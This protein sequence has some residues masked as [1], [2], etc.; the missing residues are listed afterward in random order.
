MRAL[1]PKTLAFI[2]KAAVYI[3]L[4]GCAGLS[5]AGSATDKSAYHEFGV[6][7]KAVLCVPSSDMDPVLISYN[8]ES[9]DLAVGS[10]H[11]PGFGFLFDAH[12]VQR[13]LRIGMFRVRPEL[14]GLPHANTLGG[15]VGFLSLPD[16]RRLGPA[17]RARDLEDEWS[18]SGRCPNTVVT[19]F[20]Q[21][22][23]LEVKCKATDNYS[24]VLNRAPDRSKPL[25]EPNSVVVA[26][27]LSETISAG[28]FKG[29]TLH[30]CRRV[31]ILDGFIA[32]YQIQKENLPLYRQIDEFLR[33]KIVEWKGN[34][35]SGNGKP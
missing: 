10:G 3:F 32:D 23:I 28:K 35:S 9:T 15:S 25:P 7:G 29:R 14:D 31:V 26:T 30:S 21:S 1:N 20:K 2:R 8:D 12:E 24:N 16:S 22:D 33:N 34:C 13:H 11:T 18:A 19:P 5:S 27:C 4:V 6:N 17:G